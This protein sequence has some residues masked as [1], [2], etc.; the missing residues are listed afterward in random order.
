MKTLESKVRENPSDS[1]DYLKQLRQ[2]SNAITKLKEDT[3]FSLLSSYEIN[4]V[5]RKHQE[6]MEAQIKEIGLH[7]THYI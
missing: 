7:L 1:K 3:A 6:E 5:L 2:A 4:E